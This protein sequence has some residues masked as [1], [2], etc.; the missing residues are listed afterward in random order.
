MSL[1]QQKI[2]G[3]LVSLRLFF[4]Q[5]ARAFWRAPTPLISE[6]S[7]TK[8]G[9][10]LLQKLDVDRSVELIKLRQQRCKCIL[11]FSSILGG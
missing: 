7:K 9:P 6:L 1:K 4:V 5:A 2:R 8:Q 11:Q 10:Y 3:G